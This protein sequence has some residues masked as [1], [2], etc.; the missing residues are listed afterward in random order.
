MRG[1]TKP[2]H[3]HEVGLPRL[4]RLDQLI[5]ILVPI[6]VA[7]GMDIH[8]EEGI[9]E[10]RAPVR[11]MGGMARKGEEG[12]GQHMDRL[13]REMPLQSPRSDRQGRGPERGGPSGLS[14]P[15]AD[16]KGA[17]LCTSKGLHQLIFPGEDIAH[18]WSSAVG[19]TQHLGRC[20]GVVPQVEL[21]NVTDEGLGGI[22]STP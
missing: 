11:G 20:Q 3:Y 14:P 9:L 6:Q 10:V 5:E 22:K 15:F 7:E 1:E 2:I 21:C 16:I 17:F 12:E 8:P 13:R 4:P 19:Y 18:Q